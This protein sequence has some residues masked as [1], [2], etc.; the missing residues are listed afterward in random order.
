MHSDKFGN[1]T[2]VANGGHSVVDYHIVSTELFPFVSNF[3]VEPYDISDH[4]PVYCQLQFTG[5]LNHEKHD[6]DFSPNDTQNYDTY[7][8]NE[9]H[10]DSF[11]KK[12]WQKTYKD[13]AIIF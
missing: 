10:C 8:W 4:F 13:A 12:Y 7:K 11:K 6:A 5:S 3:N 9:K 1:F 2:C